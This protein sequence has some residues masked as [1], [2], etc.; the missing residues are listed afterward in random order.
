M[1]QYLTN[2]IGRLESNL[3]QFVATSEH[4][5]RKLERV[6]DR[7]DQLTG[8]GG[9]SGQQGKPLK[10][11]IEG[12]GGGGG[13][14]VGGLGGGIG[15]GAVSGS[16][17]GGASLTGTLLGQVLPI[18]GLTAL[19]ASGYADEIATLGTRMAS[20]FITGA[21][22]EVPRLALSLSETFA[23]ELPEIAK[24]FD[25]V[26]RI[27]LDDLKVEI[28]GVQEGYGQRLL[29]NI[30]E[31]TTGFLSTI[32]NPSYLPERF[33]GVSEEERDIEGVLD[34][35]AARRGV[36]SLFDDPSGSLKSAV[37]GISESIETQLEILGQGVKAGQEEL[38]FILEPI[39]KFFKTLKASFIQDAL[40]GRDSTL[41][42]K[43]IESEER[44]KQEIQVEKPKLTIV[45][46]D[47]GSGK[48]VR[49]IRELTEVEKKQL[50]LTEKGDKEEGEGNILRLNEDLDFS[51]LRGNVGQKLGQVYQKLLDEI[52]DFAEQSQINT[53]TQLI[54]TASPGALGLQFANLRRGLQIGEGVREILPDVQPILDPLL[55]QGR[56]AQGKFAEAIDELPFG[57]R[58][59]EEAVIA[60]EAIEGLAASS[61]QFGTEV[62]ESFTGMIRQT[63]GWADRLRQIPSLLEDIIYQLT[64]VQPL[65]NFVSD[66]FS[67]VAGS[68]FDGIVA[69]GQSNIDAAGIPNARERRS[70]VDDIRRG[71]GRE[72]TRQTIINQTINDADPT[73]AAQYT[74]AA[75]AASKENDLR[76]RN[77]VTSPD[78]RG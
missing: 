27:F 9:R 24:S 29:G 37:E 51:D 69:G 31:G 32:L 43:L 53:G 8:E 41:E 56:E 65:T 35:R 52:F 10:V 68:V 45:E 12:E 62:A 21:I 71:L 50:E 66:L 30:A 74:D 61:D 34:K 77:R 20:G 64:I 16:L 49:A 2:V 28:Q 6:E 75:L 15:G 3:S 72:Q 14:L 54:A 25:D 55:A 33:G 63:E 13:G 7:L 47:E 38:S 17:V 58:I 26:L 19:L 42:Q 1:S 57:Q 39:G 36:R 76:N 23:T 40:D 11:Q 5:A 18:A 67:T 44:V 70:V 22:K 78:F 48:I 60:E 46:D 59:K 73:R 4:L